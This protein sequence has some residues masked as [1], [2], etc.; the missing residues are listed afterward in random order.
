MQSE[1][2][3]ILFTERIIRT[4]KKKGGFKLIKG[5]RLSVIR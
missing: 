3:K 2:G 1:G 5:A 4:G